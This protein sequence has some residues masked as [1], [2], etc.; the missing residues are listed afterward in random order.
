MGAFSIWSPGVSASA[1]SFPFLP[2]AAPADLC[3]LQPR[4]GHESHPTGHHS[5][6]AHEAWKLPSTFLEK[7]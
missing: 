5:Q 7:Q 6:A 3:Y 1:F 2:W 4:A